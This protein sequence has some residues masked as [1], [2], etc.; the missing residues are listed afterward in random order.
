MTFLW[1]FDENH[2]KQVSAYGARSPFQR[3]WLC[4]QT[5][6]LPFSDLEGY[7]F[8]S[9]EHPLRAAAAPICFSM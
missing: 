6:I 4:G 2:P 5:A 3:F 1:S 7:P 8:G 9:V